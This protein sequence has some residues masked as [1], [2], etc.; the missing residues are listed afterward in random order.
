MLDAAFFLDDPEEEPKQDNDVTEAQPI[1]P[2]KGF[3]YWLRHPYFR[4]FTSYF[5]VFCNFLIFAEDPVSHS[6]SDCIVD[7]IGNI[8]AFIGAR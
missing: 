6:C 1:K 7:I 3:K 5:V 4:I 2:K 8:Y